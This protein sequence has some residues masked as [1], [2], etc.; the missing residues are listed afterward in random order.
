V[1]SAWQKRRFVE[2]LGQGKL[3]AYPT[4]AIFGLGCDPQNPQ[5]V[6]RLLAVKERPWQKGLILIASRFSQ[7]QPYVE[8]LPKPLIEKIHDASHGPTTWV[9]PAK[10]TVTYW[11]SGEHKSIA[12]RLVH[13][14]LAKELCDLA[15]SALV[16]TSS[17]MTGGS[18][19]KSAHQVRLKF[20]GKGVHIIHGEVGNAKKPSRIIDIFSNEQLR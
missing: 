15:N 6:A 1:P 18:P 14:G 20:I 13:E 4:E 9:L 11:L 3:V 16:S 5:A 2:Q 17:N 10:K 7:L 8:N 12:V 19:H